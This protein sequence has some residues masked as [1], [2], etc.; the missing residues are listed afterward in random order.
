MLF[1]KKVKQYKLNI[2]DYWSFNKILY[3]LNNSIPIEKVEY[4]D[5]LQKI[6]ETN[7][8]SFQ[9]LDRHLKGIKAEERVRTILSS[10]MKA[11]YLYLHGVSIV[12]ALIK[13]SADSLLNDENQ[14]SN[15]DFILLTQAGLTIIEVKSF[16]DKK[17]TNFKVFQTLKNQISYQV[18][19][20]KKFLQDRNINI[21]VTFFVVVVG[22][23]DNIII[24]NDSN[25]EVMDVAGF[26]KKI[27]ELNTPAQQVLSSEQ[28]I[29]LYNLMLAEC[30]KEQPFEKTIVFK[31]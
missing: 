19:M 17:D 14:Y 8:Q 9:E 23:K 5:V 29:Y 13:S 4:N 18:K 12:N 7:S 30:K 31:Y 28:M 10:K 26:Y 21:P 24:N 2:S 22:D 27:E 11:P 20:V 3:G 25:L 1:K 16:Y 15:P 6:A